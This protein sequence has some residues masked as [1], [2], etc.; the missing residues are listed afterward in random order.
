MIIKLINLKHKGKILEKA[1]R[2]TGISIYKLAEKFGVSQRTM[3]TLFEREEIPN[4]DMARYGK[5]LGIDFSREIPEL[6]EFFSVQEPE[7][8]YEKSKSIETK[9]YSLLEKHVKLIEE[10]NVL[11]EQI[12]KNAPNEPSESKVRQTRK[13]K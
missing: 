11:K 2:N 4:A 9:Y 12:E 1:V 7:A 6:V 3:Y 5:V 10:Y 13:K 8:V